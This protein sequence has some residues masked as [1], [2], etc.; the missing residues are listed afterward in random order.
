[1]RPPNFLPCGALPTPGAVTLPLPGAPLR[2][3]SLIQQQAMLPNF[4]TDVQMLI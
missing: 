1:M 4:L 3:P 2:P